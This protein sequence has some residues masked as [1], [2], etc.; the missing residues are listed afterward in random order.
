MVDYF[1]DPEPPPTTGGGTFLWS[2]EH[3]WDPAFAILNPNG[4]HNAIYRCR[5]CTDLGVG[6]RVGPIP[7]GYCHCGWVQKKPGRKRC[8]ECKRPLT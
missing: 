7:E 5:V 6:G 2:H 8:E 3:V 1:P 4:T